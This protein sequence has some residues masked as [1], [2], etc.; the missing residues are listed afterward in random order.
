MME[1]SHPKEWR[2][3][4]EWLTSDPLVRLQIILCSKVSCL[5]RVSPARIADYIAHAQAKKIFLWLSRNEHCPLV[6]RHIKFLSFAW[7]SP[8]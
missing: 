6:A 1:N 7:A 4:F 2:A 5:Y 8:M 3:A